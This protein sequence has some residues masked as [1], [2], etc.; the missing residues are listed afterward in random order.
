MSIKMCSEWLDA[1]MTARGSP[2]FTWTENGLHMLLKVRQSELRFKLYSKKQL[3]S[4]P[5]IV[6]KY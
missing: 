3:D 2:F 4:Y 6:L 1:I 5:A